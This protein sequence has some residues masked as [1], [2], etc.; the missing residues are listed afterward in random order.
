VELLGKDTVEGRPA[1]KLAVTLSTGVVR[2]LY[3]DAETFLEAKVDGTRRLRRQDR[4]VEMFYRD[5]RPVEASWCPTWSRR[6]WRG[7]DRRRNGD[8]EVELNP[9]LDDALFAP[10]S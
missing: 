1:Y 5:Y 6:R 9:A 3:L 8:R 7:A 2:H 4:K 10:P